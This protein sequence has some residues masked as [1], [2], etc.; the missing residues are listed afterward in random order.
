MRNIARTAKLPTFDVPFSLFGVIMSASQTMQYAPI[1]AAVQGIIIYTSLDYSR[2]YGT[3]TT[4]T[5]AEKA[6]TR[7]LFSRP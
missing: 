1:I 4:L 5:T 6:P 7:S 2:N 3:V